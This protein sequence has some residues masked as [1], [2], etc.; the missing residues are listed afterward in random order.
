MHPIQAAI[1]LHNS[2]E[3]CIVNAMKQV[4]LAQYPD[5]AAVIDGRGDL[6][7]ALRAA[8][9][10]IILPQNQCVVVLRGSASL[11]ETH[12][13]AMASLQA[14]G[15]NEHAFA[16]L[17]PDQYVQVGYARQVTR[18]FNTASFAQE[19]GTDFRQFLEGVS[20]A[21]PGLRQMEMRA[22]D[23]QNP[24]P[25]FDFASKKFQGLAGGVTATMAV[26][27]GGTVIA[28][29]TRDMLTYGWRDEM[30]AV[31]WQLRPGVSMNDRE[32][33]SVADGDICLMRASDWPETH[34]PGFHRSPDRRRSGDAQERIVGVLLP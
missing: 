15:R 18:Q 8:R 30:E 19:I 5:F 29:L 7:A 13:L 34:L 32:A 11:R 33:W 17:A 12:R 3:G 2:N 28:G 16:R 21:F 4:S 26:K 31:T 25:H 24:T 23:Y 20:Q 9:D 14:A 6:M 10:Q 27:G 22:D 1:I